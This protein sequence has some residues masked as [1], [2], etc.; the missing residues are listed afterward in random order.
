MKDRLKLQETASYNE[1]S[2]KTLVRS[3][4]MSQQQFSLIL[5]RCNYEQLRQQIVKRLREMSPLPIQD[6]VLPASVKTL[7]TTL[8]ANTLHSGLPPHIPVSAL[9]VFGLETVVAID[10]LMASTN[11]VRDEFRKNFSCP[12]VLWVTDDIVTKM[13]RLAPDFKSWAAATIKFEMAVDELINFMAQRADTIFNVGE[14]NKKLLSDTAGTK[15]GFA[16]YETDCEKRV[17]ER[18]ISQGERFLTLNSQPQKSRQSEV[19]SYSPLTP[20]NTLD[21]AIGSLSRRELE[22]ALKDLQNRGQ[23][24][25]PALEASL[26]F[27][28]GRDYYVSDRTETALIHYQESLLFWQQQTGNWEQS[29][30]IQTLFSSLSNPVPNILFLEREGIVLFHIALCHRLQAAR[31]PVANRHHWEQAWISLEQSRKAFSLAERPEL[32][33]LGDGTPR[34]SAATFGSLGRVASIG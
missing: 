18:K 31:N 27:V 11:Q 1:R 20:G 10:E 3:I 32:V 9:M 7:Y 13:I 12:V 14:L 21:L 33:A 15:A 28:L 22:L 5:V 19:D 4:A 6:L 29:E 34:R 2:L 8:L 30:N 25:E 26:Q 16:S 17:L 24:L 23:E